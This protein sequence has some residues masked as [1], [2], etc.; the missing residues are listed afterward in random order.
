MPEFAEQPYTHDD[1]D[2]ERL[3]RKELINWVLKETSMS[4]GEW[5]SLQCGGY[6]S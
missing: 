4:E 5:Q 2:S 1:D 3:E 6:C